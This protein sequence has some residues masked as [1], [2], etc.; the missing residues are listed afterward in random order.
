MQPTTNNN[1]QH[2][3]FYRSVL[4]TLSRA[5][6]P[7]LV[8]GGF[9]LEHFTG[10]SRDIKD[11]DIFV[12][13]TDIDAA[14][15][16]LGA[17]G[18]R[19]ELTFSHW[20]GKVYDHNDVDY[21][22]LIFSSG[23]GLCKVDRVWFERAV[24]GEIFEMPVFL[25]PPEE[26]IWQKSF[27]MERERYDGADVA[28]LILAQ[29]D[30]LDWQRVLNLFGRHWRVFL[31]H[32]ILF[33]YIYP[34]EKAKVPAFVR[35]KLLDLLSQ[36]VC[37]PASASRVC[38]GSFLSRAQFQVDIENWSYEDARLAHMSEEEVAQ[39]S[40]AANQKEDKP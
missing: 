19:S 6:V 37:Q 2:A 10:I 26:M 32:L 17:A 5:G 38:R 23:N 31:S 24:R 33:D 40:N 36:E 13:E 15:G 8:S 22:D 9:A 29:G 14:L 28:H 20:L 25:C 27:I 4:D 11:L 16:A 39:W 12:L 1:H 34:A 3:N 7:F 21:V 30:R 18:Y 35:H